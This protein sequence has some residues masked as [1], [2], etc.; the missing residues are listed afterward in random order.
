M[1]YYS[2]YK[3]YKLKYLQIKNQL[4]GAITYQYEDNW[5]QEFGRYM[6]WTDYTSTD[7]R[8]IRQ[9]QGTGVL[10]LS[11]GLQI[12]KTNMTQFGRYRVRRIRIKPVDDEAN[13]ILGMLRQYPQILNLDSNHRY[14]QANL[15]GIFAGDMNNFM[16]IS[17]GEAPDAYANRNVSLFKAIIELRLPLPNITVYN[18]IQIIQAEN[19]RELQVDLELERDLFRT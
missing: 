8:L 12:N 11:S 4:G 9:H 18:I 10:T 19:Q 16:H 3:K 1:D 6:T 14:F 2:K 13:L 7:S 17:Q 15:V 5:S